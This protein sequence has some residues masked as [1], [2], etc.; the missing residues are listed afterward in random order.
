MAKLIQLFA[1]T[2]G[3]PASSSTSSNSVWSFGQW[4]PL[5]LLGLPILSMAETIYETRTDPPYR[6]SVTTSPISSPTTQQDTI[7]NEDRL[8]QAWPADSYQ[9][10]WFRWLVAAMIFSCVE[11]P[12][13]VL[14][15]VL[16]ER[17]RLVAIGD[18]VLN[19]I[20]WPFYTWGFI[21]MF[22][23]IFVCLELV[24]L[25]GFRERLLMRILP[26]VLVI[27]YYAG[28]ITV[29]MLRSYTTEDFLSSSSSS[30]SSSKP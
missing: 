30:F 29:N 17:N 26:G 5:L 19:V 11:F 4:L 21:L 9:K 20:D 1:A 18:Y 8:G 6:P 23:T 22:S 7:T 12:S 14:E 10:P 15:A 25:H 3:T 28:L 13:T 27:T 2:A 16:I 24:Q